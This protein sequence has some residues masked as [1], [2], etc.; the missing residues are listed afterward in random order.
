[1]I[2]LKDFKEKLTAEENKSTITNLD[3][4]NS[5]WE[6]VQ[7]IEEL[8]ECVSILDYALGERRYQ[9]NLDCDYEKVVAVVS[10]GGSE[11][12]YIDFYLIHYEN[13]TKMNLGTFKTLNEDM[14][15]YML[16]GKLAGALTIIAENYM[17]LNSK[18]IMKQDFFDTVDT[19]HQRYAKM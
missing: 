1:M 12:I 3:M 11:G 18:K 2:V 10:T 8:K 6:V 14:S 17:W 4:F 15:A 5:V 19:V 9:H 16:M 7:E 13:N